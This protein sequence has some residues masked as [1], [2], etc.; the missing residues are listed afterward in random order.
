MARN[1]EQR[2]ERLE[3]TDRQLA[4]QLAETAQTLALIQQRLELL[5]ERAE[6]THSRQDASILK[7]DAVVLGTHDKDGLHVR[8]DR[9]ENAILFLRWIFGGG[10]VAAGTTIAFLWRIM[11]QL[12]NTP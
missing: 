12:G 9:I 7:L 4:L 3:E 5:Y 10:L 11:D 6:E 2:L 1:M 8:V